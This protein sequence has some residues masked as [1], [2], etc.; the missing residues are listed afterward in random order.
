MTESLTDS[1]TLHNLLAERDQA[2]KT[3]REMHEALKRQRDHLERAKATQ[4][5][6]VEYSAA[7]KDIHAVLKGS[8]ITPIED[9]LD[10]LRSRSISDQDGEYLLK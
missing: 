2:I 5:W 8:P 10:R 3:V 9:A 4:A 1:P 6:L 7:L